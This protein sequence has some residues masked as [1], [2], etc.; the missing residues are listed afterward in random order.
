MMLSF[1]DALVFNGPVTLQVYLDGVLVATTTV[2]SGSSTS[3][4]F[5]INNPALENL[6]DAPLVFSTSTSINVTAIDMDNITL[7]GV[8]EPVTASVVLGGLLIIAGRRRR[9]EMLA[10]R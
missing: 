10:S 7:T 5:L 8:P 6:T 2:S 3:Q 4:Q 9:L 1:S